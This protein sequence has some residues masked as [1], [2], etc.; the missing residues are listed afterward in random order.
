MLK[1]ACSIL[2]Y[3]VYHSWVWSIYYN[4]ISSKDMEKWTRTS[5]RWNI[6]DF[7]DEVGLW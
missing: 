2:I 6:I 1:I 5:W 4:L 3:K 7:E